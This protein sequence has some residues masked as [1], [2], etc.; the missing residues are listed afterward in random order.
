MGLRD[1]SIRKKLILSNMMMIVIP[2]VLILAIV[3]G[4]VFGFLMVILPENQAD[5]LF[6]V[7]GTV[8]TYQLQL[9]FDSMCEKISGK[10]KED[11]TDLTALADALEKLGASI[12]VTGGEMPYL[13]K[14][15]TVNEIEAEAREIAGTP[16][17]EN[18]PIFLRNDRGLVY[19]MPVT[20]QEGET[21]RLLVVSGE[22]EFG[23]SSYAIW[24]TW[25][26]IKRTIKISAAGIAGAAV[27]IV[28]LTGLLLAG[29][30]YKTMIHSIKRIQKGAREIRDGVLDQPVEVYSKDELGEV[31]GDFEEMRIRLKESVELQQRYENSRKELIAGIS[32]DLSTPL[33]SIKGYTSGLL[34]G[35]ANTPEKQQRYLHTIYDTACDMEELVDSLFLFSKLDMGKMDFQLEILSA[36]ACVENF[37]EDARL[38]V[39][40]R[41]VEIQLDS[42]IEYERLVT[43]DLAQFGRV[44]WNLFEN[45]LKYA[46]EENTKIKI[47]LTEEAGVAVLR[48][49][50]NGPGVEKDALEKIFDSFYRTDP[51][52]SSQKKGSGLGL[53]ITREIIKGFGGSIYAEPSALGGLAMIIHLPITEDQDEEDSDYRG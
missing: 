15:V 21:I 10:D 35:V 24:D 40:N 27:I 52:R 30:L 44:L 2:V 31:C 4:T 6:K 38:K 17:L 53:S 45:S 28:V 26:N 11:K 43:I 29:K 5:M 39:K 14:G 9:A 34:D 3:G 48:F 33:T 50:D 8:S 25:D 47:S 36:R 7:D 22:M 32:H 37:C 49:E 1:W 19:L 12:A 20:N 18:Q 46:G 13:T 23:E 42:Q 16:G 41:A 51:A